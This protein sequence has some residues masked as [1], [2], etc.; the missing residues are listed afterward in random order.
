MQ[1]F[2]NTNLKQEEKSKHL[3]LDVLHEN[4]DLPVQLIVES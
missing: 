3:V 2:Q 4:V 1:M